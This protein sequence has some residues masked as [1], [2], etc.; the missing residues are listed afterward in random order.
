MQTNN[1]IIQQIQEYYRQQGLADNVVNGIPYG[2][3][4]GSQEIADWI[5]Q[6]NNGAGRNNPIAIP[7]TAEEIAKARQLANAPTL[8]AK[9]QVQPTL[10]DRL[11]SG[12][13]DLQ[14]GYN[15]NRNTKFVPTNLTQSKMTVDSNGNPIN[16]QTNKNVMNRIGEALGTAG[17]IA[18]NPNLQGLVAGGLVGALTGSPMAGLSVGYNFANRKNMTDVLSQV[19]AKNGINYNPGII[20]TISNQD[21]NTLMTPTYKDAINKLAMAKLQE[22]QNYH[23]ALLQNKAQ[24]LQIKQQ[25]ANTNEYKAKNGTKV[26][27]VGGGGKGGGKGGNPITNEKATQSYANDLAEYLQI[28][29]SGNIGKIEYAKQ[30]FIKRH[31][32]IN[33]DKELGL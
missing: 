17:R 32:G 5:N 10:L 25:N 23:D 30:Q 16:P 7:Q 29:N 28:Y 8:R 24:E 26:T 22:A 19:L 27:H 20:G 14:A 15:E 33:P 13:A 21:F 6:Y 18:S 9:A 3:N 12:I 11:A 4:S 2:L 1:D 31:K